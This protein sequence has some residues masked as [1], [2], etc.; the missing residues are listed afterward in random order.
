MF[1]NLSAILLLVEGSSSSSPSGPAP[2]HPPPPC[3]ALA[4][5]P[6]VAPRRTA[7]SKKEPDVRH[8]NLVNYQFEV[9]RRLE[10]LQLDKLENVFDDNFDPRASEK[11]K[12]KNYG[13]NLYR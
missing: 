4:P 3:P 2:S 11:K 1:T 9:G 13:K 8:F 7:P 12:D 6:P 10:N 5:P